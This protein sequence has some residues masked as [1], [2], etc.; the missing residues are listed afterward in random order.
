MSEYSLF[1][2][3][4]VSD[5]HPD[6]LA[7][8]VSD[9]LLDALLAKDP[10]ARVAIETLVTNGL[11]VIAGEVRSAAYSGLDVRGIARRTMSDV[12]YVDA[13]WGLDASACG[14]LNTVGGQS[15][16]IAAKVDAAKGKAQGAG[17]QGMMFGYASNEM[18]AVA[19][20]RR[21]GY[22][23]MPAP[24]S[25]AHGLMRRHAELRRPGAKPHLAWLGPDAKSQVTVRYD[26]DGRPLGIDT[27]VLSA[28]YDPETG[29]KQEQ[30]R[31]A[32]LCKHIVEPVV[33]LLP[34][35]WT[36]ETRYL[37]NPGGAFTIGGPAAD[38]GLTG[39]KIIV[40]TY[41][42]MA[43]HGGGA[44]SGKDPSKVDRSAAYLCRYI[45]KH[46]VHCGLADRCEVQLSFAIGQPKPVSV[47][48]DTFGTGRLSD[49][50]LTE[51]VRCSFCDLLTPAEFIDELSLKRPIYRDTAAFGHFGR[52]EFP[53]E[54]IDESRCQAL[55]NESAEP[56]AAS[57]A[58]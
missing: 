6:K 47:S 37:F 7:D 9:A 8:Q 4:S 39:R 16:E 33:Q 58:G 11:V 40:D 54:R 27:V 57:A 1:T 18:N 22:E 15:P 12:G 5:G 24:I 13:R 2:S 46:V 29:P 41:G 38:C 48:V 23:L 51:R 31:H 34:K 32:A 35:Q 44:F 21:G 53:W 20:D 17:D 28:Q 3:E 36:R 30:E 49:P 25:L 55:L 43:R 26:R 50:E 45:A 14:V 42:G 52:P 56:V 10:D 19:A